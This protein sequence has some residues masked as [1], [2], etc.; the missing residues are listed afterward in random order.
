MATL[1]TC[2]RECAQV[3]LTEFPMVYSL[4]LDECWHSLQI[5]HDSASQIRK[6][7]LFLVI[8]TPSSTL[9]VTYVIGKAC[10]N[11][12]DRSVNKNKLSYY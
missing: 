12:K 4:S 2:I 7:S 8:F 6:Y 10:F 9:Y 11:N 3:I 5:G 1:W